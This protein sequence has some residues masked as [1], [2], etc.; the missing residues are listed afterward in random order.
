MKISNVNLA[1]MI[2]L[3]FPWVPSSFFHSFIR[4]ERPDFEYIYA[5]NGPI[6]ELRNNLVEQALALG[7]THG[8]MMDV[9]QVYHPQTITKLMTH[10]L[11]IVGA[12]VHRRY[13]P[14]DSLM[15]K[16]VEID[17]NTNGYE[18]IDDWED[19]AL[20]EVDATGAG[21]LMF[22]MQVF[23]KMPYPWFKAV[24][25]AN[26]LPIG[27]DI[28]FCQ[29]LKAAGYQIFVDTSVPAGHLATMIVNRNTNLLY[30]SMKEKQNKLALEKAL[31]K[32]N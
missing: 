1:I 4:M 14:F 9:D 5:D 32:E 30:R 18:S 21:C 28:G 26:G 17:E 27:E 31:Q 22:D 25:Q 23:R 6:H 8:I 15:L 20:V 12:V 29:E 24:K 7:C 11:P 19:G 3:S 13:P 16:Q 2:P 10:K